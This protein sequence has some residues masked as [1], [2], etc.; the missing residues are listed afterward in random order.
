MEIKDLVWSAA[1]TITTF[2]T[3]SEPFGISQAH[4]VRN[5]TGI[6]VMVIIRM[7]ANCTLYAEEK[8]IFTFC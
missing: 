2:V 8:V 4:H 3:I 5:G 6:Q 1:F 7:K